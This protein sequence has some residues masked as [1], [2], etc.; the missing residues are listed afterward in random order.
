MTMMGVNSNGVLATDRVG[1]ASQQW[2]KWQR[3]QLQNSVEHTDI[4]QGE[5]SSTASTDNVF[6]GCRLKKMRYAATKTFR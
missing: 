5:S 2:Q 3:Q 4:W 1:S 6:L